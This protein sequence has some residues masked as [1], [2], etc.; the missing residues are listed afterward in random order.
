MPAIL[1]TY[2]HR[3]SLLHESLA[4]C[5]T[6]PDISFLALATS[7]ASTY[8]AYPQAELAWMTWLNMKTIHL[9]MVSHLST[10]STQHRV[11]GMSD[12][13]QS[14]PI[15]ICQQK[16]PKEIRHVSC[17]NRPILSADKIGRFC[18]SR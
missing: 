5:R 16:L 8:F 2:Q 11:K 14:R 3:H 15:F 10:N 18:W 13:R 12:E 1:I 7:F 17:K 4:L 6:E 9:Q